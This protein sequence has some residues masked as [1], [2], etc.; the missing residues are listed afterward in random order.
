MFLSHGLPHLHYSTSNLH[1]LTV[2]SLQAF[3]LNKKNNAP[4]NEYLRGPMQYRLGGLPRLL[5]LSIFFLCVTPIQGKQGRL[6]S[7]FLF[8]FSLERIIKK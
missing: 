7:R 5:Q 2:I 1:S 4:Y 3:E 6:R 8:L